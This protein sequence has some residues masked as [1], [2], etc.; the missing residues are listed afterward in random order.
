MLKR[1]TVV[2]GILIASP[3]FAQQAQPTPMELALKER[4]G[5]EIGT[6]I[7]SVAKVID[8]QRQLAASQARVKA[9]EDKYEPKDPDKK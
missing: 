9:L 8:L 3:A 1:I 2:L 6:T 5:A 7:D 4:L